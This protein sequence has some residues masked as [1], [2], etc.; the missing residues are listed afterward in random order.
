MRP[1]RGSRVAE[2]DETRLLAAAAGDGQ[3]A[4]E[5][6]AC[7]PLRIPH[8]DLEPGNLDGEGGR[9]LGQEA[10][11][12][13]RGGLVHQVAGAED[14]A[15]D[16]FDCGDHRPERGRS[17]HRLTHH[18]QSLDAP[19]T[20]VIREIAA[21]AVAGEKKPFPEGREYLAARPV[22]AEI[23]RDA[24]S[25]L[26]L[27]LLASPRSC[28]PPGVI[29]HGRRPDPEEGDGA[30]AVVDQELVRPPAEGAVAEP[31]GERRGEPPVEPADGGSHVAFGKRDEHQIPSHRTQVSPL[32]LYLHHA[33]TPR[34]RKVLRAR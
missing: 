33:L 20:A 16:R 7:D 28:P 15:D 8:L 27:R 25:V 3:Q 26:P 4:G 32:H 2:D 11:R 21:E 10:R 12:L 18:R 23:D 24:A 29:G 34:Q 9:L 6:L 13:H 30:F 17:R 19:L 5:V 31:P 1:G 14:L 22:L